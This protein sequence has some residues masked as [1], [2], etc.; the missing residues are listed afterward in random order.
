LQQSAGLFRTKLHLFIG[1]R[2]SGSTSPNPKRT[3]VLY[4]GLVTARLLPVSANKTALEGQRFAKIEEVN[5]EAITA[6][7]G[8]LQEDIPKWIKMSHCQV[9]IS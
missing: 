5:A 1:R 7:T 3:P 4:P 6:M 8:K 9:E 2:W